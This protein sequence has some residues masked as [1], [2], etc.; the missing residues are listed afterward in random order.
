[1]NNN[2]EH[3]V[4]KGGNGERPEEPLARFTGEDGYKVFERAVAWCRRNGLKG[5]EVF[6]DR[7]EQKSPR[8]VQQ[9]NPVNAPVNP[10]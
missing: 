6:I 4:W 5:N 3:I 7:A 1:M 10:D 8:G 2:N 9:L